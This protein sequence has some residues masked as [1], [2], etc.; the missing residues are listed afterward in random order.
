MPPAGDEQ[1]VRGLKHDDFRV[2]LNFFRSAD[3]QFVDNEWD[4][5]LHNHQ[6][7]VPGYHRDLV[8]NHHRGVHRQR[9]GSHSNGDDSRRRL[10]PVNLF[11]V[12]DHYHQAPLPFHDDPQAGSFA[13]LPDSHLF[14]P[15]NRD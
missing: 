3:D 13:T 7:G 2:Q 8:V 12:L 5:V 14:Q 4:L 15:M 6:L 11:H 1:L 9:C 10:L